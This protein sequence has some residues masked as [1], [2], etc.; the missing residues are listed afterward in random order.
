[1]RGRMSEQ[2]HN[3]KSCLWRPVGERMKFQRARREPQHRPHRAT[4]DGP[5]HDATSPMQF[6][7]LSGCLVVTCPDSLWLQDWTGGA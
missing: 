4:L 7:N 6:P 1:M 2:K 3:S 5:T